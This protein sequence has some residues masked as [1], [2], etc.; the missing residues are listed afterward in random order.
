MA[1]KRDYYEVLGVPKTAGADQ[2]KQAYRKLALEFHP[3]RNKSP[4]AT[5][6]FKEISEA[7]AVLSDQNK[8][9]QYDQYGHAGFDQMY[10]RE[11]IF[12]SA[13]FSDFEDVF[14]SFGFSG[15]PFGSIFGSAFSGSGFGGRRGGG[16]RREY[17]SD[18]QA[19]ISITL[20]EA[21]KGAKKE[22]DYYHSKACKKCQGSGAESGSSRKTCQSCGG[23][24][25][26]QQARRM[27]PMQFYTVTTCPKCHG[28][29]S[30]LEKPCRVCNG[31]GNTR[32]HEH[33][34]VNIP[35]GIQSGMR[36]RLED[37]GEFGRDGPGDLYVQV[38]VKKH[39]RFERKD[40]DLWIDVPISFSNA[41][42]GGDIMIRTLFGEDKLHIPAGTQS[43]T[44]FRMRGE[45]MPKIGKNGKGDMMVRVILDVPKKLTGKQKEIL[46]QFD[47]EG[48]KKG[49]W[50]GVF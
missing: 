23:R 39:E 11:D 48:E 14:E 36:L 22:I 43:H 24:G 15:G 17:G 46:Q 7:Y 44:V 34:N 5:E 13:D 33:I 49:G 31:S 18:L 45:G 30:N 25:Q 35:P 19:D 50:L 20:E 38:I 12:R 16:R 27:G 42:L 40:D 6:K 26:V 28:E 37:L 47:N 10:S 3:D 9:A 21:A 32:E 41:A 8:R 4:Q 2:I 1:E 29:G